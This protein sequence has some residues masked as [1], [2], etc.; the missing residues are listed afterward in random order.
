MLKYLEAWLKRHVIAGTDVEVKAGKSYE[1]LAGEGAQIV[2]DEA[3]GS[4]S[5]EDWQR[6]VVKPGNGARVLARKEASQTLTLCGPC[7]A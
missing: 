7:D 5:E 6:C 3:P 2:F 4:R 1:T